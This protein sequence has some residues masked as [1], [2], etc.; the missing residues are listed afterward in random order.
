[1]KIYK[2]QSLIKIVLETGIASLSGATTLQILYK[3]PDGTSGNWTAT[4]NGTAL[5]Y[6]VQNNDIDQDGNWQLQA[7]VVIGGRNGYGEKTTLRV[8]PTFN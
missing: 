3:K 8:D 2:N 7:Y 5:E 1:M 4:A 6:N